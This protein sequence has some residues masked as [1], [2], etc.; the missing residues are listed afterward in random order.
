[1]V[2]LEERFVDLA[3][4]PGQIEGISAA[5][6]KSYVRYVRYIFDYG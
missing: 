5:D 2:R 3:F 4:G 6:I 1:M